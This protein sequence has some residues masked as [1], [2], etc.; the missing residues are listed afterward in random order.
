MPAASRR[1]SSSSRT[2]RLL[3]VS[4]PKPVGGYTETILRVIDTVFGAFAQAAPER[5]QGSPFATINALSLAGWRGGW[6][7]LGDVLLLR[8]RARRQPGRRRPQPRQQP[9]LD[10][11]HPAA[12]DSRVALSGDVHAMG[13]AARIRAAPASIAAG[14]ARSTRSRRWPTATP[15]CSCSASAA[16]S[17]RSAS[18]AADRRRSTASSM[19][20]R[21]ANGSRRSSPRSPTC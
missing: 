5:A 21:K 4:A 10:R 17:R 7:A 16:S 9:D 8:R 11:H 14:S 20:P 3:G 18:M 15:R 2:R 6:P 13:A 1:S 12:G 19:T